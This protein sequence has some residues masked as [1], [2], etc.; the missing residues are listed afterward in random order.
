MEP[1]LA[2]APLR[3]ST[4]IP[5]LR[6]APTAEAAISAVL[7][8]ETPTS[9]A[10]KSELVSGGLDRFHAVRRFAGSVMKTHGL[11]VGRTAALADR[12]RHAV[13]RA[14]RA[15][16]M[17]DDRADLAPEIVGRQ[18]EGG[19]A[20][21]DAVGGFVDG[22][23]GVQQRALEAVRKNPP[24]IAVLPDAFERGRRFAREGVEYV[25]HIVEAEQKFAQGAAVANAQQTPFEIAPGGGRAQAPGVVE[26]SGQ[27]PQ[28]D[29][30]KGGGDRAGG[31]T[32]GGGWAQIQREG[33]RAQHG[34]REGEDGAGV[35]FR[36][37]RPIR[38]RTAPWMK[39]L[40]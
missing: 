15:R 16:Q 4:F 8:T 29:K 30:G 34:G 13:D 6:A 18:V 33:S 31:K 17:V 5:T 14:R 19:D 9:R 22:Q 36:E 2:T 11:V 35:T 26:G 37:R 7:R 3:P 25:G 23:G 32:G 20:R 27:P 28:I 12:F 40:H 24:K 21:F 38:H 1:I 39:R 10:E